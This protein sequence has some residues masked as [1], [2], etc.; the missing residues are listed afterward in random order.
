MIVLKTLGADWVT[1]DQGI[2][3]NISCELNSSFPLL[4]QSYVKNHITLILPISLSY[5]ES[6]PSA[7]VVGTKPLSIQN[8]VQYI[9]TLFIITSSR[10]S[11]HHIQIFDVLE[12]QQLV[13]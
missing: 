4:L 11:P 10:P 12:R 6:T 2:K 8:R 13:E 9:N 7:L 5:P 1:Y 3:V